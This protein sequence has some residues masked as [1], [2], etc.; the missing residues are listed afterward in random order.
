M[1]GFR[2][3]EGQKSRVFFYLFKLECFPILRSFTFYLLKFVLMAVCA[4][5]FIAEWSRFGILEKALVLMFIFSG[6]SYETFCLSSFAAMQLFTLME[7]IIFTCSSSILVLQLYMIT[8]KYVCNH[9]SY[10][11]VWIRLFP[12]IIMSL[13]ENNYWC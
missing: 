9:W 3:W 8:D 6:I 4:C 13:I 11:H 5:Q 7:E 10:Y 12:K 2:L 1:D